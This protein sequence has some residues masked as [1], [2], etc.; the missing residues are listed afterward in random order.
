MAGSQDHDSHVQITQ[1]LLSSFSHPMTVIHQGKRNKTDG[2]YVLSLK[3]NA[4][5]EEKVSEF[6]AIKNYYDE[7]TEKRLS[8]EVESPFGAAISELK[9][10]Q[11]SASVMSNPEKVKA[12]RRYMIFSLIRAQRN[13]ANPL[14][15]DF[16]KAHG[17]DLTPSIV[18][19]SFLDKKDTFD[20]F[21]DMGISLARNTSTVDFV[22]PFNCLSIMNNPDGDILFFPFSPREVLILSPF[23]GEKDDGLILEERDFSEEKMVCFINNLALGTENK[24]VGLIIGKSEGELIRL[25]TLKH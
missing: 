11:K 3:T 17:L 1:G 15:L 14:I 2:I 6:G 21:K 24:N 10:S 16:S 18:I 23:Y 8:A 5:T 7:E 22:I 4:I 9:D 20:P 12:I 13:H 25:R 19:K